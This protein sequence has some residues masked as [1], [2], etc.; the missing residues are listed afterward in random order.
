MFAH[1]F[2]E[3]LGCFDCI[4]RRCGYIG[5]VSKYLDR[6]LRV[7]GE[8]ADIN[9]ILQRGV[10]D[11]RETLNALLQSEYSMILFDEDS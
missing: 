9:A 8:H 11:G 7:D 2:T 4:W 3:A 10:G 5:P 1:E 6:L